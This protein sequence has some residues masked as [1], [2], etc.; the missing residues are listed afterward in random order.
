MEEQTIPLSK[1]FMANNYLQNIIKKTKVW[2]TREPNI[3]SSIRASRYLSFV[4]STFN[5]INLSRQHE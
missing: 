1:E 2:A 4:Q 5:P 3:P